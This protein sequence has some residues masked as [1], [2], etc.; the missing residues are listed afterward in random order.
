[1]K[2]REYKA[3]GERAVQAS[4]LPPYSFCFRAPQPVRVDALWLYSDATYQ[5]SA[6]VWGVGIQ[7]WRRVVD[8]ATCRIFV[9]YR[10][11][12]EPNGGTLDEILGQAFLDGK[13]ELL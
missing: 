7:P 12:A 9:H 8:A 10:D 1:M 2:L 11:L 3:I 5:A 13:I 4:R 6:L